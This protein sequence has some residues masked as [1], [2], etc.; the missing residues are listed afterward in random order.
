MFAGADSVNKALDP[1]VVIVGC[2]NG[3]R[4]REVFEREVGSESSRLKGKVAW[5]GRGFKFGGEFGFKLFNQ[6]LK[7]RGELGRFQ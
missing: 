4:E 2:S 3:F 7:F 6:V 5:F 1:G